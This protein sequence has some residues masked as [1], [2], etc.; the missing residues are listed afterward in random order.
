MNHFVFEDHKGKLS[1]IY[2]LRIIQVVYSNWDLHRSP[3]EILE[4]TTIE[5]QNFSKNRTRYESSEHFRDK[6]TKD[7]FIN[8]TTNILTHLKRLKSFLQEGIDKGYKLK[9][10]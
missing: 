9:I 10:E 5:I 1:S 4:W 3:E 7:F 8:Q 2:D 6:E